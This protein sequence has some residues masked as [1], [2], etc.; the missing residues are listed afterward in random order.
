MNE[1]RKGRVLE[2][3]LMAGENPMTRVVER[4]LVGTPRA[5]AK[6]K[7][8]SCSK[9]KPITNGTIRAVVERATGTIRAETVGATIRAVP[10]MVEHG[11]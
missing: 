11:R 8:H 10:E 2:K 5:E 7:V 4:V 9:T 1:F 3:V 6:G